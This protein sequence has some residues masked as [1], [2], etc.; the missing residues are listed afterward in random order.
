MFKDCRALVVDDEALVRRALSRIL[1]RAGFQVLEA[2]GVESAQQ[3]LC[4]SVPIHLLVTDLGLADGDG[5]DLARWTRAHQP[6]CAVLLTTGSLRED[7]IEGLGT[8]LQKPFDMNT[9]LMDVRHSLG[10]PPACACP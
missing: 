3:L 4:E 8:P 2:D 6:R 9:L 10:A 7:A 5:V 1:R